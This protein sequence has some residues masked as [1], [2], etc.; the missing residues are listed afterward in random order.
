VRN[1][2]HVL[3]A[4]RE[5]SQADLAGR[6]RVSRQT[7]NAIETGRSDPSLSLAF[8][9]GALFDALIEEVFEPDRG[10]SRRP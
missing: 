7:I 1:R 5:W 2:L 3:R 8:R 6:L 9:I 10:S 4:E